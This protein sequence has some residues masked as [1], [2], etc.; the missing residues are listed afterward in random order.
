[1]C[2]EAFAINGMVG[3]EAAAAPQAADMR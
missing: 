1:M 3:G 2:I